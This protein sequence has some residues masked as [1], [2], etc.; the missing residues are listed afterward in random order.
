MEDRLS[1]LHIHETIPEE[2][3]HAFRKEWAKMVS[4]LKFHYVDYEKPVQLGQDEYTWVIT[5]M[6]VLAMHNLI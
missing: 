3:K 2:E 5:P 6:L 4:D 1:K